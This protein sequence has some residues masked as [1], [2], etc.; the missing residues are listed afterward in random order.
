MVLC[1]AIWYVQSQHW[2]IAFFMLDGFI[3]QWPK[4]TNKQTNKKK[5][6]TNHLKMVRYKNWAE[7]EC[8]IGQR[9]KEHFERRSESQDNKKYWEIIQGDSR[10]LHRTV[11]FLDLSMKNAIFLNRCFKH[12]SVNRGK[13]YGMFLFNI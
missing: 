5:N 2:L 12:R 9:L 10:P 6:P 11:P 4:Q 3:G 7:N 13:R 8:K 1:K